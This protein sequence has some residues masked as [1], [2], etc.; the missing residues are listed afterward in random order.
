MVTYGFFDS[1]DGDRKYNADDISNYFLKLISNG[2]FATPSSSMQVLAS[3]GMTVKVSQGWGFINCKWINND[4]DFYLT[5]DES[6]II[7]NRADRIVLRLNQETRLI[8]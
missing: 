8:E 7:L 5:L 3:S 2:V 4:S 1:V 6:D